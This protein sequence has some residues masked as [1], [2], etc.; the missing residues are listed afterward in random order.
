MTDYKKLV[1]EDLKKYKNAK[2]FS[3]NYIKD[4]AELNNNIYDYYV[5]GKIDEASGL[6]GYK[7]DW[8]PAKVKTLSD[9]QINKI[10]DKYPDKTIF[11]NE[12]ETTKR[13]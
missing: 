12:P 9:N 5:Y 4:I 1:L 13:H 2:D 6:K 11:E 10:L 7:T 8:F 3:N